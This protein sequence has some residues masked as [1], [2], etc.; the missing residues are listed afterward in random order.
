MMAVATPAMLPVPIDAASAVMNAWNGDSTPPVA[1]FDCC[2]TIARNASGSRRNLDDA[3]AQR[4]ERA[5]AEQHGTT[6][7]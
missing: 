7:A 3:E 6:P 1:P 2:A 5:R 4:Q